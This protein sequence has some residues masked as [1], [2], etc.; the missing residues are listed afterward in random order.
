MVGKI[1]I[2]LIGTLTCL[3][4]VAVAWDAEG[5]WGRRHH[6]H[7]CVPVYNPCCEVVSEPCCAPAYETV[8]RSSDCCGSYAVVERIV[9]TVSCC[10]GGIA[11]TAAPA[12]SPTIAAASVVKQATP[13]KLSS[14]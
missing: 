4:V 9:P 10:N 1:L 12:S 5:G 14:K 7:C 6:R 11:S 8:V 13:A 3:A 2:R